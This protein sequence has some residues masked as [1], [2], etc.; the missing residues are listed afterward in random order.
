MFY[1]KKAIKVGGDMI[2]K[3]GLLVTIQGLTGFT[4][5]DLQSVGSLLDFVFN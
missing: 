5:T 3:S 4:F 1:R 2:P